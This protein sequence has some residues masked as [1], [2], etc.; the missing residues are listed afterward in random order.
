MVQHIHD[1]PLQGIQQGS[2]VNRTACKTLIIFGIC[3]QDIPAWQ[4]TE[5]VVGWS[6]FKACVVFPLELQIRGG[7]ARKEGG[8]VKT[9]PR[10][11]SWLIRINLIS[12]DRYKRGR[13]SDSSD[14][15]NY[16]IV[17]TFKMRKFQI[18]IVFH[19]QPTYSHVAATPR[20]SDSSLVFLET[21][22]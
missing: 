17:S 20:I 12:S 1:L 8:P 13:L 14:V 6:K 19:L 15:A 10:I 22:Q 4:S 16:G 9:Y 11:V 18:F 5:A 3:N 21:E 7:Y 2:W